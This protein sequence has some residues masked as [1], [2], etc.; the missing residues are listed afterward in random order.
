MQTVS[1]FLF[2]VPRMLQVLE[3]PA[4]TF[5]TSTQTYPLKHLIICFF[6]HKDLF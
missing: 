5:A 3:I 1:T 6:Q 4:Q 2:V